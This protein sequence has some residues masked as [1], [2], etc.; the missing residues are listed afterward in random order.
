V[1]GEAKSVA[2]Q[3]ESCFIDEL[4]ASEV[5]LEIVKARKLTPSRCAR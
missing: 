4:R 3:C 1:R 5:E 2:D